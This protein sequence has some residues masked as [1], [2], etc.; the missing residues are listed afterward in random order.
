MT[1]DETKCSTAEIHEHDRSNTSFTR[2]ECL[3][4]IDEHA[5][6]A[7]TTI[8]NFLIEEISDNNDVDKN[9]SKCTGITKDVLNELD[10]LQH[11]MKNT[12]SRALSLK[13]DNEDLTGKIYKTMDDKNTSVPAK[14]PTHSIRQAY[15]EL[16]TDAF[17][18]EID[19]LRN[20]KIYEPKTGSLKKKMNSNK[21][22]NSKDK[23][24]LSSST[25]AGGF[26]IQED[27]QINIQAN[28]KQ[29]ENI[30]KIDIDVLVDFLESG[31]DI[32]SKEEQNFILAQYNE[33][34]KNVSSKKQ[35]T[36]SPKMLTPH[37]RRRQV[38][39]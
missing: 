28:S 20:G 2:E 13:K 12:W 35:C 6:Q 7:M 31:I 18:D 23:K 10:E 15:M 25:V 36:S 26:L 14:E 19:A 17:G 39:F 1:T 9:Y 37:E 22:T 34:E 32:L 8:S 24:D 16:I 21:S 30:D 3:R 27:N 29:N 11:K 4:Q 33:K 5:S 38:I